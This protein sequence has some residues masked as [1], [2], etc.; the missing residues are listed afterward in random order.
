[1]EAKEKKFFISLR[2]REIIDFIIKA[3]CEVFDFSENDLFDRSNYEATKLRKLVAY[4]CIKNT[5][6]SKMAIS[7]KMGFTKRNLYYIID[8]IDVHVKIYFTTISH[9]NMII[10]KANN[11]TKNHEWHLPK[12]NTTN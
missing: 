11:F 2:D 9:L 10:D 8:E 4:L 6:A 12:I 7:E 5:D 1:M 3:G